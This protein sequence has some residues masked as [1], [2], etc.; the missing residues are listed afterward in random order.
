MSL[1]FSTV[2]SF[3]DIQAKI[4][5]WQGGVNWEMWQEAE[6]RLERP[7]LTELRT[8]SFNQTSTCFKF[9]YHWCCPA[10][11]TLDWPGYCGLPP[12]T[13]Q[14][15]KLLSTRQRCTLRS[16]EDQVR[17]CERRRQSVVNR[18]KCQKN[19]EGKVHLEADVTGGNSEIGNLWFEVWQ[20]AS[21]L[22]SA[23]LVLQGCSPCQWYHQSWWW[24]PW[25][26]LSF[27][28]LRVEEEHVMPL[29]M[30]QT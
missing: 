24:L 3:K 7:R 2:V 27:S 12:A 15:Y 23:P 20:R 22:W 25:P 19:S 6:I 21:P 9:S 16:H 1:I 29:L 11:S 8:A 26:S 17:V 5:Q 10:T 4:S 30:I 28:H 14:H 13:R 18:K